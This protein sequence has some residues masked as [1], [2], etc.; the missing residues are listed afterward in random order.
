MKESESRKDAMEIF[1]ASLK[2]VD[3]VI[4]VK[5]H[6]SLEGEVL[7]V[8]ERSY[9][10]SNYARIYVIGCG[11]AAASMSYA[12][13]DVLQNR[14]NGGIINV[15]YGHTKDL[16][17]VKINEAGHPIPDEAGVRGAK[18]ILA[19]LQ[20]L[21]DND[22][23]IFVFSGGGSALLPLPK[24]GFS[25]E[26][27]QRVT[28]ML[29]DSGASI[30]EMNTVRKHI[31]QVKGGQ[32]ARVAYPATL[33][34]LLLSDVVGE[35]I[36]VIAS[37]PTVPDESTFGDCMRI[38]A[39]YNLN[40]PDSVMNLI[41]KG[42]NGELEENPKA[43]DAIFDKTFHIIIG[44]NIMA[45]KAAEQKAKELGYNSLILSSSIEGESK[46]VAKVLAAIA[47]EIH[48]TGNP[49]QKPACIIAGGET[50][51]TIRGKGLGGRNQ[52]FVLA[53]AIE[54]AGMD[55]TV[56][57]SCGTDGTDG[58]TDAAGAI[59]DGF[60]IQRAEKL[61]MHPLDYLRNNDSY[62]FFEKLHDL[63]KTGPTNTNVMDVRLV[64]V[65]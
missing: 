46:G 49:I 52:E 4:A 12:L 11:K 53:T 32:L 33:I 43:G 59:A 40:L 50:T 27:K 23:V 30:A 17:Y 3:P 14:I 7:R 13:E 44:S 51:V 8:G 65:G 26:E 61:G 20:G 63:I 2:A 16:K 42:M 64:L 28:K 35:R 55:D 37:G 31:S 5:K 62:H 6:V 38:V 47:K 56:I 34:S 48:A 18:E 15:K 29:L 54:I 57:L 9:E 25:L 45:L 36:D 19:L 10:L 1:D 39:K 24:D 22:L 60:T 41:K 58:P 21:H